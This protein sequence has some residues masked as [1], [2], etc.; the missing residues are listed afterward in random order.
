[1]DTLLK[2]WV[3]KS[4]PFCL[5]VLILHC[6][7]LRLHTLGGFLWVKIIVAEIY[8]WSQ[9]IINCWFQL[10][11]WNVM[12]F[13]QLSLMKP[14]FIRSCRTRPEQQQLPNDFEFQLFPQQTQ[15][16]Y[17]IASP[18]SVFDCEIIPEACAQTL[19]TI[20]AG[21]GEIS[22]VCSSSPPIIPTTINSSTARTHTVHATCESSVSDQI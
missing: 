9:R 22:P 7:K 20:S 15:Y 6:N 12:V 8:F 2:T 4:L 14:Q 21:F 5:I 1:M 10:G 3:H 17:T 13:P 11:L 18:T 19:T 16:E